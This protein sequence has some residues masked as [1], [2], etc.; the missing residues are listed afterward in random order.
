M[1]SQ[2]LKICALAVISAIVGVLIGQIKKEISFALKA[3]AGIL[4]FGMIAV[5]MGPLIAEL[6]GVLELGNV[7]EYTEIMLKSLGIAFLTHVCATL[8]RDCGENGLA[9][10]VEFAGKLEILILCVPLIGKILDLAAQIISM[11]G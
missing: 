1:S 8:C 5:S 3:A 10:G 6:E 11:D 2:L 7:S 9:G 4:V